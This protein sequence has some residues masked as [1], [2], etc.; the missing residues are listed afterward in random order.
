MGLRPHLEA[1]LREAWAEKIQKAGALTDK[2]EKDGAASEVLKKLQRIRNIS[3]AHRQNAPEK[4]GTVDA[5]D[6]EIEAFYQD[7]LRVVEYLLSV[8]LAT[9]FDLSDTADVYRHHAKYFWAAVRGE[10]TEGHP[11]YWQPPG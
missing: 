6:D 5:T 11:N 7:T 1:H 8:V 3:L 9:S 2:Y 4:A 10:R